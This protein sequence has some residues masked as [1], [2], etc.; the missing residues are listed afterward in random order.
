MP[1]YR[2]ESSHSFL[3]PIS[4]KLRKGST[5]Q[6]LTFVC[7]SINFDLSA[8]LPQAA[9][10]NTTQAQASSRREAPR[11]MSK[12]YFYFWSLKHFS[13]KI[14]WWPSLSHC[15]VGLNFQPLRYILSLASH[16]DS[17]VLRVAWKQVEARVVFP[18]CC[19]SN[20]VLMFLSQLLALVEVIFTGD[21]ASLA[22]DNMYQYAQVK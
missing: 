16:T 19:S 12:H 15:I 14:F 8:P 21:P 13:T 18:H 7:L 2:A 11:A 20:H 17:E 3:S 1:N 4:T 5:C 10:T 6:E 22:R 9:I